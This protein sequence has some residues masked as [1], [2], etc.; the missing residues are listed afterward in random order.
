MMVAVAAFIPVRG[1]GDPSGV[2]ASSA[3]TTA[4]RKQTFRLPTQ[5]IPFDCAQ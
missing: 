5:G 2:N 4:G 3:A 1:G